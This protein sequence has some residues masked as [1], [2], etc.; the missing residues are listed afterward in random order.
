MSLIDRRIN[1]L[2]CIEL[3]SDVDQS[4]HCTPASCDCTYECVTAVECHSVTENSR[5]VALIGCDT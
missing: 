4:A 5:G 3:C 1:R 2:I